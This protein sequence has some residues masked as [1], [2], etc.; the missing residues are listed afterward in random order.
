[1]KIWVLLEVCEDDDGY[2]IQMGK[3][4][5]EAYKLALIADL[6]TAGYKFDEARMMTHTP[7]GPWTDKEMVS[8][9]KCGRH[10]PTDAIWIGRGD[11][12]ICE[13]CAEEEQ[14]P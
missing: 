7:R 11:T 12:T 5:L 13:K 2:H 14:Q 9:D 1:M 8:C 4:Y 3:S 6:E 10:M